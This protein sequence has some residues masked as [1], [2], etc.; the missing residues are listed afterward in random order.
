MMEFMTT[1]SYFWYYNI[2][3]VINSYNDIYYMIYNKRP[4]EKSCFIKSLENKSNDFLII[5]YLNLLSKFNDVS[6]SLYDKKQL[7]RRT[8]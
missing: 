8:M 7:S 1:N 2:V 6:E 5:T 3:N 4:I